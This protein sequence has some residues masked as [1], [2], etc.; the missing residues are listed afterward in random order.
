[1]KTS[2]GGWVG[3]LAV[4]VGLLIAG[5][6]W[7]ATA[8]YDNGWS[9]GG[10]DGGAPAAGDHVV[11][12]AGNLSWTDTLPDTVASWVQE[13]G[14]TNTVTFET[15]YPGIGTFTNFTI[16]GD[17]VISNGVWTHLDGNTDISAPWVPYTRLRVHGSTS[18][19]DTRY[20][21]AAGPS[22]GC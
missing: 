22:M 10:G 17:C 6:A 21:S 20:R 16:T 1:M 2:K 15:K 13:D 19:G 7:G 18:S 11:I 5:Q 9:G 14:Y 8:V 4:M 3:T 12:R